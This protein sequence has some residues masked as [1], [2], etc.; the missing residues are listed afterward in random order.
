MHTP[1][2][3]H[4]LPACPNPTQVL[5]PLSYLPCDANNR[6]ALE[7]TIPPKSYKIKKAN[8]LEPCRLRRPDSAPSKAT[9][10]GHQTNVCPV[11]FTRLFSAPQVLGVDLSAKLAIPG[12]NQISSRIHLLPTSTRGTSGRPVLVK[13]AYF[14]RQMLHFAQT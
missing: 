4:A 7:Q 14:I 1:K 11:L 6:L 12:N 8:K 13:R 5:P 2:P 3:T 9:L 10:E